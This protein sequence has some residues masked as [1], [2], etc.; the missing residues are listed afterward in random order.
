M[1]LKNVAGTT[2]DAFSIF[3]VD[4]KLRFCTLLLLA[5]FFATLAPGQIWACSGQ[6]EKTE[7]PCCQNKPAVEDPCQ[8]QHPENDC[9]CNHENDDCH[10]PGCGMVSHA[11]ATSALETAPVLF[12]SPLRISV[13]KL[14]FY[15]AGHL[16]EAVYLPI[17]QPPK[18][19][20]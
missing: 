9:P 20:A 10:C 11:G 8:D 13:Q 3:T 7:K 16:P 2:F 18:L 14:A 6:A 19:G 15:Y 5:L 1:H 17:W 12:T 4:M